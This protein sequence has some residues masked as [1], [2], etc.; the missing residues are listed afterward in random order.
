NAVK[1]DFSLDIDSFSI[2]GHKFLGCP[3]PCG[4]VLTRKANVDFIRQSVEYIGSHDCTISGSRDGFS[5][6]VLWVELMRF[7]KEGLKQKVRNCM[8]TTEYTKQKLKEIG[9]NCWSNPNSNIVVID[10]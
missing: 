6:L 9:W 5:C 3:V 7:G 10:R 1:I 2:S 4:V 8:K